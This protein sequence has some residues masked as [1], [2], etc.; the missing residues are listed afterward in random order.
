M[1]PVSRAITALLFL[2]PS[3]VCAVTTLRECGVSRTY[4]QTKTKL[5]FWDQNAFV[6][7][8]L[9]TSQYK[10]VTGL[11][12]TP[13]FKQAELLFYGPENRLLIVMA[14]GPYYAVTDSETGQVISQYS[15]VASAVRNNGLNPKTSISPGGKVIASV[16]DDYFSTGGVMSFLNILKANDP[17]VF[18][19]GKAVSVTSADDGN[20][21]YVVE[22]NRFYA[23]DIQAKKILFETKDYFDR[24][25]QIRWVGPN[26]RIG[27]KSFDTT[28]KLV[29]P[30]VQCNAYDRLDYTDDFAY[31]ADGQY[32]DPVNKKDAVVVFNAGTKNYVKLD[33]TSWNGRKPM[34]A[35][36]SADGKNIL[37]NLSTDHFWWDMDA[38]HDVKTGA[39]LATLVCPK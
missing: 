18:N 7:K 28:G 1:N 11:K 29:S 22:E 9:L 16:F 31:Y 19:R 37:V 15:Q 33:N 6:I 34:G 36:F 12:P 4:D 8:N 10:K 25:S 17:L 30:N 35:K 14:N 5:V 24:D 21:V 39:V 2:V 27:C 13:E 3:F 26:L 38:I 20:S 23:Y 32:V